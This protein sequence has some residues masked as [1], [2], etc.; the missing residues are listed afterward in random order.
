MQAAQL[1]DD[2]EQEEDDRAAGVLE[3][4][5][6]LSEAHRPQGRQIGR[7]AECRMQNAENSFGILH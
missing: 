1:R 7:N 4:L 5:P 3:I 6:V 2:E